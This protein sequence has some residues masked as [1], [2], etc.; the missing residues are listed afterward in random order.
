MAAFGRPHSTSRSSRLAVFTLCTWLFG[1]QAA[2]AGGLSDHP[3]A[4][5]A[6]EEIGQK[7]HFAEQVCCYKDLCFHFAFNIKG[8]EKTRTAFWQPAYPQTPSGN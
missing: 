6:H 2:P 7:E 1:L 3:P 8:L 5:Q 4:F